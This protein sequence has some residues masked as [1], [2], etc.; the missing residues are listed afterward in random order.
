MRRFGTAVLLSAVLPLLPL[1]SA[2]KYANPALNPVTFHK[3]SAGKPLTLIRGGAPLFAIVCDLTPETGETAERNCVTRSRRSVTLALEVLQHALKTVCGKTAPVLTPDSPELERFAHLIVLGDNEMSRKLGFDGSRLV[4]D[5]FQVFTR[6]GSVVIAG[7]DGSVRKYY[8]KLDAP[9]LRVNGT[10]YGVCDFCERFL[11]MRYYYPK[12]GIYAPGVRDLVI[13]PVSYSDRPRLKFHYSYALNGKKVPGKRQLSDFSPA[14][15]NGT[16]SRFVCSH[17]PEPRALAKAY[18]DKIDMLFFRS[19]AGRLFFNPHAHIGSYYDITN[20]AFIDFFVDELVAKFYAGDTEVRK[21]W[22]SSALPNSEYV[23]FGQ[24]DTY[25]SD[26][27]NDRSRAYLPESTKHLRHGSLSDLYAH[28]NIALANKLGERFPGKKLATSAYS[29]RTLPPV[30]KYDWPENLRL[31]LCMGCP[32]MVRSKSFRDAWKRVAS[33]W[34]RT[35]GRP[36]AGYCYGVKIFAITRMIEGR[37]MGEFIKALGD[38]LWDEHL[39]FDAGG[40][41]NRFYC[42]CYPAYRAMWNSDFNVSAAID[43][44]WELLYGPRAGKHLKAFYDLLV[45]CW[46]K[47]LIPSIGRVSDDYAIRGSVTPQQLYKAYDR[48]IIGK[49]AAHLDAARRAVA[50]GS[51]EEQRLKFFAEPWKEQ[52]DMARAGQAAAVPFYRIKRLNPGEKIAVDG[53]ADEPAWGRADVCP[54]KDSCG[55]DRDYPQEP[56]C[57][58]L[59]DDRGVYLLFTARGKPTDHPGEIWKNSDAL[60][61]FLSPGLGKK[62]FYQFAF[63]PNG[64]LYQGKKDLVDDAGGAFACPGLRLKSRY[65][66]KGW[67]AELFVPFRG[68]S[69]T[70]PRPYDVWFGNAVYARRRSKSS[71]TLSA[72]FALTMRNTHNVGLWGQFRFMGRGD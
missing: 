41:D 64:D 22:G 55:V 62:V 5:E 17:T 27:V 36:V 29:S 1:F 47:R 49:L 28:F 39:F 30:L 37:Y 32:V 13:E 60:E 57:R 26:V 23:P 31:K 34:H 66:D 40:H 59:W 7:F 53:R 48:E 72:S 65:D 3:P 14:W 56:Q 21:A 52:F 70:V 24:V 4:P 63:N 35:T 58:M 2:E 15:R 11:G 12:I 25:V 67:Q 42:S 44:H 68:M 9:R 61:F 18:P 51:L 20:P 6:G 38:D 46:E 45:D 8:D 19:R 43:E 69:A 50:P 10:A 71:E 16:S 54:M 33:G